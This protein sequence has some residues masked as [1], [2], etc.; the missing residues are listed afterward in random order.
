MIESEPELPEEDFHPELPE[1][2]FVNPRD[3]V[4]RS[5][6]TI[7]EFS[8]S[9]SGRMIDWKTGRQTNRDSFF[10]DQQEVVFTEEDQVEDLF[11]HRIR[12]SGEISIQRSSSDSILILE[13]KHHEPMSDLEFVPEI[14]YAALSPAE[15]EAM[16][17]FENANSKSANKGKT[18]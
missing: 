12:N 2:D 11:D 3:I 16:K 10:N 8:L 9:Q 1:E 13:H 14:D 6:T 7:E 5:G 15:I 4:V 18:I 17:K